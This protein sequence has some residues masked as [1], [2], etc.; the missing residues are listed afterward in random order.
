[1]LRN[2]ICLDSFHVEIG[3]WRKRRET[4]A[5]GG[6]CSD[7]HLGRR[8]L[9]RMRRLEYGAR[10]AASS[11]MLTQRSA[12]L[13][14]TTSL[15]REDG[16]RASISSWSRR[17]WYT[18]FKA[19]GGS[20]LRQRPHFACIVFC[21]HSFHATQKPREPRTSSLV[22]MQRKSKS[23]P[24]EPDMGPQRRFCHGPRRWTLTRLDRSIV[25]ENGCRLRRKA[26]AGT[27]ICKDENGQRAWHAPRDS[28]TP[29]L[30]PSLFHSDSH[31]CV[32]THT[33]TGATPTDK[34]ARKE[35]S[36]E[37]CCWKALRR[38]FAPVS[39]RVVAHRRGLKAPVSSFAHQESG[40][41]TQAFGV[42]HSQNAVT[43]PSRMW[44][45]DWS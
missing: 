19:S 16:G 29:H 39:G 30:T 33:V 15:A 3:N 25:G 21:A 38:R 20:A 6:S 17:A 40:S 8:T 10:G 42:L 12:T 27:T 45:R 32:H 26:G 44:S 2:G 18:L 9:D 34:D 7:L 28:R 11:W 5:A 23:F 1:M 35:V 22:L 41:R 4:V 24:V 14:Q 31:S 36:D 37:A 13:R 43:T